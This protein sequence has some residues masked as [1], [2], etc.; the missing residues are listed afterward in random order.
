MSDEETYDKSTQ[1]I[2]EKSLG[3]SLTNKQHVQEKSTQ[4]Y[5]PSS[6]DDY[7]AYYDALYGDRSRETELEAGRWIE[8]MEMDPSVVSVVSAE[9]PHPLMVEILH[10][11]LLR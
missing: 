5:Y 3:S 10:Q 9:A 6:A 8:A 11:L 1:K 2:L 4:T 7:T